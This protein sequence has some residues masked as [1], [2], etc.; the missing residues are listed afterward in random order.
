MVYNLLGLLFVKYLNLAFS[1]Y[2]YILDD[3]RANN[4]YNLELYKSNK[5]WFGGIDS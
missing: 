3:E 4:L 2:G 5:K 1:K